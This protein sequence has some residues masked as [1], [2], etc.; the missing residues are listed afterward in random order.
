M[1][2]I[3]FNDSESE[4]IFTLQN[5]VQKRGLE[6]A[7]ERIK[8]HINALV[9]LA[10]AISQY[11]SILHSTGLDGQ[12]R[13]ADS[14]MEMLCQQNMFD[15]T[16]NIPTKAVL[17]KGFLVAKI[18]FFKM[19]QYLALK[20]PD[21]KEKAEKINVDLTNIVF[22]IM[23]EEVFISI[24]EDREA[25][26]EVRNR[27]AF[28]LANI[29]EYRLNHG[30]KDFVP[31]LNSVWEARKNLIPVFGTL[32]GTSELMMLS[33]SIDPRWYDFLNEKSGDDEIFQA[34]EEF[35]FTLTF[36]ELV[37]LRNKMEDMDMGTV[38]KD[39]IKSII[40]KNHMYTEFSTSDPRNMYIFFKDRKH[41]AHFRKRAGRMGP[42]KTI[43]EYIMI[44]LLSS[45]EWAVNI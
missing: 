4:L 45:N 7:N 1:E 20:I 40:G 39:E 41:N 23:C 37:K 33:S 38:K 6:E 31:I 3:V 25:L 24:I 42:K 14:V 30:M 11:P 32:M 21:I 13:S 15:T 17:G 44:H 5:E 16:M 22:T 35:L 9:E 29:W 10:R 26:E 12:E 18:N 2:I 19:L 34:L 43:E 8:K 27:A 36:E 28:L